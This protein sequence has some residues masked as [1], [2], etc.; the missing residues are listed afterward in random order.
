MASTV[1]MRPMHLCVQTL[2]FEDPLE[3]TLAF[4]GDLGVDGVD[5]HCDPEEYLGDPD[6]Q[7]ALL[8]TFESA[9]VQL[10]LL[11]ATGPNV[12][13]PVEERASDADE[14]LRATI[15]LADELGVGTVSAFSGLPGGGPTDG[16]PNWIVA[17]IPPGEQ[18]GQYA[19]QWEEVAIPYWRDLAAFADGHDVDVAIEI[20]VN[21]LVNSPPAL[22]RLREATNERIGAYVD[23]AHLWLQDVDPVASVRYLAER[24]AIMHV[25]A[26]DV[27][28]YDENLRLRGRWDMTPMDDELG[29]PWAFCTVGYGHGADEWGDL[30]AT[31]DLVGYDGPVSVQQ[32]NTPQ[33]LREGVA[34]G[35]RFLDDLVFQES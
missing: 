21:M 26:S 14:H 3:E 18:A 34:K 35:V 32:L 27:V 20:H 28:D 24:D 22:A 30:L 10:D 16:T 6:A 12:L 4:L 7:A 2:P 33:P 1:E 5:W 25:E 19:Y 9:G 23:P 15:E 17:P 31:L 8:E 29:R 11:G 13:H